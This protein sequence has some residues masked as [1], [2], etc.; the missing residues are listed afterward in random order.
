LGVDLLSCL[1]QEK[2][3]GLGF[4]LASRRRA[5][6]NDERPIHSSY[7][8]LSGSFNYIPPDETLGNKRVRPIFKNR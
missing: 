8:V 4:S 7:R 2:S 6:A 5:D 3:A 1:S